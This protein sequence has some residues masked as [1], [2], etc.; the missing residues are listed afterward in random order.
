MNT[1]ILD[2]VMSSIQ[3]QNL[4]KGLFQTA[5]VGA[6]YLVLKLYYKDELNDPP[7]VNNE[8]LT[9]QDCIDLTDNS[10]KM[11]DLDSII[12]FQDKFISKFITFIG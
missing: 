10:S 6:I 8:I 9:K 2:L 11:I 12:E 7:R 3:Y 1:L 5:I 4:S